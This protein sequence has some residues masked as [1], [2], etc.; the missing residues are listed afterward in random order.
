MKFFAIDPGLNECG[1]AVFEDESLWLCLFVQ[2]TLGSAHPKVARC[3]SMAE[4]VYTEIE[5]IAP[6]AKVYIERM[7]VRRNFQAAWDDLI[8][9]STIA[10]AIGGKVGDM[11]YVSANDWTGG[12]NKTQNHPRIRKALSAEERQ[13]LDKTLLAVPKANHKEVLDAVGIGLYVLNR[14]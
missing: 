4:D 11:R 13:I 12:R 8:D 2:N 14:L 7:A 6:C 10:G 1:V 5:H 9:L 3:M